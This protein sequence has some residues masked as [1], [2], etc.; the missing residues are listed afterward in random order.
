VR[1]FL[2]PFAAVLAVI[3]VACGQPPT[4]QAAQPGVPTSTP[5]PTTTSKPPPTA[6]PGPNGTTIPVF[7]PPYAFG[8]PQALVPP[9]TEGLAPVVRRI[10]T[11][12]PYVFITID[13]GAV[14]HPVALELMRSSGVRPT[15]F[16]N[17]KYVEG[18]DDYFKPLKEQAQLSVQAH[19][20]THPNLQGKPYEAQKQEICGNLDFLAH[21]F[22]ARP[23]LF[24][25]PFGN[26]DRT[27]R[28]AATD[29]GVNAMVLWTASVNDGVVQFQAGNKLNAGDIVLMHFRNTF[30]DDYL[31]FLNRARQDGLTPVVLDDFLSTTAP[32]P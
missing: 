23:K 7:Q 29:C 24:R 30:V 22:G 14:R 6:V 32:K 8:T 20:A 5:P 21:D 11:T 28:K 31:A 1:K 25:P 27:T 3:V 12:K 26:Y 16:L 4:D 9:T 15:L 18:H 19:T 13:D 17:T 10:E 2:V